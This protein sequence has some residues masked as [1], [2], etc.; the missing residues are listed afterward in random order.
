MLD[1]VIGSTDGYDNFRLSPSGAT[2]VAMWQ[3]QRES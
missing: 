3:R 2:F 1:T